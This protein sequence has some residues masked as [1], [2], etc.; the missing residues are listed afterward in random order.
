MKAIKLSGADT[1]ATL[2]GD[3]QK[4]EIVEIISAENEVIAEIKALQ[5]IT[6]GNKISLC[7]IEQGVQIYKGGHSIGKSITLI[8]FGQ[9]VHVQNVRSERLDI[10]ESVIQEIIKQMGI[11]Q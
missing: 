8:P 6:F 10:P 9:L 7:D 11:E 4:H 5:A 2:L 1:V 3:V